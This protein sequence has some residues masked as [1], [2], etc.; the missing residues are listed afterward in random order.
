MILIL[1][2]RFWGFGFRVC[3]L[4]FGIL[5][6]EFEVWI[7]GVWNFSFGDLEIERWVFKFDVLS[8]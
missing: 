4:V 1:G 8:L 3:S 6:L 7:Y 2:F 5:S